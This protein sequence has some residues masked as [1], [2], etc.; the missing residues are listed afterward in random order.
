MKISLA[1]FQARNFLFNLD[2]FGIYGEPGEPG[3][4]ASGL[5]RPTGRRSIS[6]MRPALRWICEMSLIRS[7]PMIPS[8]A[9][10]G[11]ISGMVIGETPDSSRPSE[12]RLPAIM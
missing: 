7:S 12:K 6:R 4:L 3:K 1:I 8:V 2:L 11:D 5:L 9:N 10:A